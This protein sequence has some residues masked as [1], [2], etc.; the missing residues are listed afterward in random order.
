MSQTRRPRDAAV[1][2]KIGLTSK[3]MQSA[4]KIDIPDSGIL[5]DDMVFDEWLTCPQ[6]RF[7]QPRIEAEIAFLMG[8][9]LSAPSN[10]ADV[11]AATE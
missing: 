11:I 7:I 2:W 6:G 8:S 9:D 3:A 1:G 5:F 4:L 10:R